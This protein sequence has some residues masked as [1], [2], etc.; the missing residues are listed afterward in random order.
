[1]EASEFREGM[2]IVL[3][4]CEVL[5]INPHKNGLRGPDDAE[6]TRRGLTRL[7]IVAENVCDIAAHRRDVVMAKTASD[8]RDTCATL[9]KALMVQGLEDLFSVGVALT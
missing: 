2:I 6:A 3:S 9:L 5:G 8:L 1:M 4:A 7:L